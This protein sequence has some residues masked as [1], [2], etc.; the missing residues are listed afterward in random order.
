MLPDLYRNIIINGKERPIQET[1]YRYFL[2]GIIHLDNTKV[3][4]F[5]QCYYGS[6]GDNEKAN[7]TSRIRLMAPNG[8]A[9]AGHPRLGGCGKKRSVWNGFKKSV[10]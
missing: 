2:K 8:N 1:V 10:A 7:L 4:T 9:T 5:A 3:G 6:M